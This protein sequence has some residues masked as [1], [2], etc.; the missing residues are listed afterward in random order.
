MRLFSKTA[1]YV[2]LLAKT[3]SQVK[4]FMLLFLVSMLMFG[5]PLSIL[6]LSRS[7]DTDLLPKERFNWWVIDSIYNQYL[8]ILGEFPIRSNMMSGPDVGLVMGMF[9]GA[10]FFT[11]ITMLNMLIAIMSDVFDELMEQRDVK[12]IS[13]KL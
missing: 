1:F 8:I 12:A 13:T 7:A 11:Q 5:L 4:W 9:C 2:Q 6:D 3:L 10:T